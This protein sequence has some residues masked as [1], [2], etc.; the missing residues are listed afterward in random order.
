MVD[1][2][3]AFKVDLVHRGDWRKIEKRC[4]GPGILGPEPGWSA[5]RVPTK[6]MSGVEIVGTCPGRVRQ[7]KNVAGSAQM[8][9][10][11][12]DL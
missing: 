5:D 4:P 9:K 6:S 12:I 10:K 1:L 2:V 8:F 7:W 11:I 3:Q